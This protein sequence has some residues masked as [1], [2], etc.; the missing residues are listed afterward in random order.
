[1]ENKIALEGILWDLKVMSDLCLHGSIESGTK[2][3]NETFKN[4]LMSMLDLQSELYTLMVGAGIYET[5]NISETK[6]SKTLN[7][8]ANTLKED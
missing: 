1:M 4:T 7:K 3:I 5:E 6:I 8:F 2:E